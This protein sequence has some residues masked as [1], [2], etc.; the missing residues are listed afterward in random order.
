MDCGLV[1]NPDRVGAQ[2]IEGAAIMGISNTLC[3]NITFS[4]GRTGAKVT[5]LPT[6]SWPEPT[7]PQIPA[8]MLSRVALRR[9]GVGEPGVSPIA[10]AICNAIAAAVGLRIR[11]LPVDPDELK[12]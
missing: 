5:P 8:S 4:E 9:V 12:A 3:S 6:T 10:P 2:Q 11:A 7:S 1:I